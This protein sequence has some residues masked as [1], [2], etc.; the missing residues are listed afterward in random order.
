MILKLLYND[1]YRDLEMAPK[2]D[3][4]CTMYSLGGAMKLKVGRG[5]LG[6]M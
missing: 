5:M 2:K 6:G 4:K 3:G 1:P